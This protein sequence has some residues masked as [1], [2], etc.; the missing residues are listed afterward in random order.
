MYN[1]GPN[2]DDALVMKPKKEKNSPLRHCGVIWAKKAPGQRLAAPD[3]YTNGETK[4][5]PLVADFKAKGGPERT[6]DNRR[7]PVYDAP[8]Q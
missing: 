5:Q 1:V 2:T 7:P 3:Y 4:E 8:A 6:S